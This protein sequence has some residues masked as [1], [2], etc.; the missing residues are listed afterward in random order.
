M[1]FPLG[2]FGVALATVILPS[3]S[4]QHASSARQAYSATMD[5]A[6]RLVFLIATPA[7]LGL[8]VLAGPMLTTLFQYNEFSAHDVEMAR[9]S[10]MAY[11]V[12]L[13]AFILIKVLASGFFSRQ[14]T[15]TPSKSA[16]WRCLLMSSLI[17]Y[18]SFH[19]HMQDWRLQHHCPLSSM[20]VCFIII[21]T[22]KV[23]TTPLQA[24]WAT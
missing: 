20:L 3:L 11:A 10:L 17:Y 5:W 4:Q 9:K 19:W 14:D 8:A 16:W 23:I 21:Y 15:L 12:G 24:G 13:P 1:E 2:V 7:A 22:K 18:W 6:L